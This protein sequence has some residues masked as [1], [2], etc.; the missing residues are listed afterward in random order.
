[1]HIVLNILN[2]VCI[3]SSC[4]TV[5][6]PRKVV[7]QMEE[8]GRVANW[9]PSI[10]N[11]SKVVPEKSVGIRGILVVPKHKKDIKGLSNY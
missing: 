2:L 8:T 6:L 9:Y 11:N 4:Q 3:G 10:P 1:M 7:A 5:R